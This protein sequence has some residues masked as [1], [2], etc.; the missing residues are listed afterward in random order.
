MYSTAG[1][2]LYLS[3]D[4]PPVTLEQY[5]SSSQVSVP[6]VVVVSTQR[7]RV[8]V[9]VQETGGSKEVLLD[10]DLKWVG[11]PDISLRIKV[12]GKRALGYE[13]SLKGA[14]NRSKFPRETIRLSALW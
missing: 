2:P 9:A 6:F 10:F 4:L 13:E 11:D 8:G 7:A 14:I 3:W 1:P 5:P 12:K